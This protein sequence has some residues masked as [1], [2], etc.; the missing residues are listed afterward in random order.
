MENTPCIHLGTRNFAGHDCSYSL[1]MVRLST[2]LHRVVS[3]LQS[4]EERTSSAPLPGAVRMPLVHEAD[5]A[6]LRARSEPGRER[7]PSPASR[8]AQSLPGPL[9][10][11]R[12]SQGS[13]G[14]AQHGSPSQAQSH[15]VRSTAFAVLVVLA[16]SYHA[17]RIQ[18]QDV[19]PEVCA[20]PA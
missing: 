15:M 11:P 9:P 5:E 3:P 2:H 16:P 19:C 7:H 13:S 4:K 20:V 8:A 18:P 10:E 12:T 1:Y 17:G 6:S 14:R